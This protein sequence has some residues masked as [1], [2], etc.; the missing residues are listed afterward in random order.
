LLRWCIHPANNGNNHSD[1]PWFLPC[2]LLSHMKHFQPSS[3]LS[4]NYIFVWHCWLSPSSH[5]SYYLPEFWVFSLMTGYSCGIL[6][7]TSDFHNRRIISWLAERVL[8]FKEDSTPCSEWISSVQ[9]KFSLFLQLGKP[10]TR[11]NK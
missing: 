10:L 8:A 11:L 5:H 1:G 6:W 3:V 4:Q 2:G 9:C 7:W